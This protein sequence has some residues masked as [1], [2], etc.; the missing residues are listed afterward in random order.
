[1]STFAKP[2]NKKISVGML[3]N[4]GLQRVL[5]MPEKDRENLKLLEL[6][7]A[8]DP[9]LTARCLALVN[10]SAYSLRRPVSALGAA[11]QVMGAR[12]TYQLILAMQ[13][14]QCVT[15]HENVRTRKF[16]KHVFSMYATIRQLCATTRKF[17]LLQ[18]PVT[19]LVLL[20]NRLSLATLFRSENSSEEQHCFFEKLDG[21][22]FHVFLQEPALAGVFECGPE[23]ASAW[24]LNE[25][26]V[27]YLAALAAWRN[28][29]ALPEAAQLVLC[30]E[31]LLHT[32]VLGGE[33]A[34]GTCENMPL[35]QELAK[36]DVLQ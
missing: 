20:L 19:H 16:V 33:L 6:I 11:L 28:Q 21:E 12:E 27:E 32:A 7:V 2:P 15:A 34:E 3:S 1:M 8:K 5:S 18:D 26:C 30:A 17:S 25:Q 9:A 4:E 10:S 31:Q 14:M 29:S 35:M 24:G 13:A 22:G 23:I 36:R